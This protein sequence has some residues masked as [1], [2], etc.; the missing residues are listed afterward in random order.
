M[1]KQEK[2]KNKIEETEG[3]I[4]G[5]FLLFFA[6]ILLEVIIML[7]ISKAIENDSTVRIVMGSVS[8]GALGVIIFL[9]AEW[10]LDYISARFREL[11]NVIKVAFYT[12]RD[13][14]LVGDTSKEEKE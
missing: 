7:L 1:K 9:E 5:A 3:R 2:I 13:Y 10:F 14:E 8:F 12:L 6:G 4:S 11:D